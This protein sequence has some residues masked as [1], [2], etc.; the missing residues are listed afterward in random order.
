MALSTEGKAAATTYDLRDREPQVRVVQGPAKFPAVPYALASAYSNDYFAELQRA[1]GSVD[2]AR[3]DQA[4]EVLLSAYLRG[5]TVFSCGNGGSASIA[6]HL[7][8]DH[9]KGVR[10]GTDLLPKVVSLSN[11]VEVMTAIANDLS[12]DDVFSFQL[13]SQSRQGDVLVAISSSG[14]SHNIVNAIEWAG[15]HGLTTVALTGFDGG[16]A[17]ELADVALHVDS[18]NYGVVEDMHQSLMHALAQYV[19]QSRMAPETLES[20]TF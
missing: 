7:Q 3:M 5:A 16:R 11:N 8:C 9:L 17:R 20:T 14:R 15:M 12:Y 18:H 1:A 10:T 19:R 4:A 13:E 6:N 2:R